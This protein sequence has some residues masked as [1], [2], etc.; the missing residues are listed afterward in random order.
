VDVLVIGGGITGAGVALDAASRGYRVGLVEAAD[1]ASGTSSRS[2]K[3]VHGGIRYL[4][5][6]HLALVREGLRE[7][8]RLLALAP[9][10]VHPLPFL[11]PL[12][13]QMRR[14]LG[15]R[16]PAVAR[17]FAP[18]GIRAGLFAYDMFAG[19][20]DLR[21][22][23]LSCASVEREA[24]HLRLEGLRGALVYYDGRTD[25]VRL[26]H[27]VLATA[28]AH[29][30]ITVNH[31]EVTGLLRTAGRVTGARVTDRHS[32]VTFEVGAR[33]VVNATGI[34]G[35]RVA[36]LD[37]PPSFRIR[38]SKGT[39]V[40][41]RTG[42]V[43]TTLALVI[44]ET[45]DGR[46]AFIVPWVGRP[47]LGTTDD[48]YDGELSTPGATAADVAYLLDHAN[49]YLRR[50][51][52]PSDVTAAWA[53]IRPLV[54]SAEN[55]VTSAVARDHVVA[56]SPGGMI[57]IVGGKLTSYRKMAEDAVDAVVRSEG[58]TRL[59]RT[60]TLRLAGADGLD[61]TRR[62]LA[63]TS[64]DPARQTHLLE[65]YGS[66]ALDA[67]ALVREDPSLA[68]P[69]HPAALPIRA[70]VVYA[71]RAEMATSLS[72][73]LF[74]RVRLAEIDAAAAAEAAEDVASLM[75][76]E[77]GWEIGE[78]RRQREAFDADL[79]RECAWMAATLR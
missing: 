17:R 63:A 50:P 38:H 25:D 70:E 68:R 60:A 49:R 61:E 72:D 1:F 62:A 77:L 2:T 56:I 74:L 41:L 8:T 40:V 26:T 13:T 48:A 29:G 73:C 55:R 58:T 43:D 75:A 11:V 71:C 32:G 59:C 53:G 34:W 23:V 39:H 67:L 44:P 65:W 51:L 15:V 9:H 66:R 64:L 46:L 31:A 12:Y 69:I 78:V 30:A 5:Q 10:L 19:R 57:S 7:R 4:P 28:R 18:L 33:F 24:P 37:P 52:H 35:Q 3:L 54:A 14:P 36:E 22:R 27:A 45:D 20:P 16:I 42:A 79:S 76:R 6:G 47:L 21:H